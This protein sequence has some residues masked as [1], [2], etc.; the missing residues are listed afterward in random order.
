VIRIVSTKKLNAAQKQRLHDAGFSVEDADFIRI[1]YK[2]IAFDQL[3]P[4]LI[5]TSANAVRSVLSQPDAHR[6]TGRPVFCVGN[7]TRRLLEEQGFRVAASAA[8]AEALARVLVA[9]HRAEAFTFF[10]GNLRLDTLPHALDE[11]GIRWNGQV[12]YETALTPISLSGTPDGILFFS[13]S[14]A[15]SFLQRQ[16]VSGAAC[17]CIGDT[18]AKALRGVA[19]TVWTA[20]TPSVDEVVSL[21]LKHYQTELKQP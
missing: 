14:G 7:A 2:N 1:S 13:P 12:A 3:N 19:E 10:H 6:L 9:G 18:T 8:N 21:C 5:F 11:A 20:D 17:F 16:P 4:N 15:E